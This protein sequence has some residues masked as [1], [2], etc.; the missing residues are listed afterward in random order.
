M[1]DRTKIKIKALNL[2]QIANELILLLFSLHFARI[3]D[4]IH[5]HIAISDPSSLEVLYM[6]SD[7][8]SFAVAISAIH[9][10]YQN[11]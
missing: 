11:D 7:T 3:W 4:I 2:M 10:N 5:N 8:P 9:H 1:K 6:D